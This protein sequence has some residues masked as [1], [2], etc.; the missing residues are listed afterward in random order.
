[1]SVRHSK[2]FLLLA[3]AFLAVLYPAIGWLSHQTNPLAPSAAGSIK[4]LPTFTTTPQLWPLRQAN[5]VDISA[6][7]ATSVILIDEQTGSIL[8]SRQAN[9][10]RP[11]ASLTKIMTAAI[12][13]EFAQ[14]DSLITIPKKATQGLPED[15]ALMG[16]TSGEQ[17]TVQELLYGLLLPSGNDAAQAL[18]MAIAGDQKRFVALMNAKVA[19]LGLTNTHFTNPSGLDEANHYTTAHDLAVITH[20]AQSFALFN[21]IVTTK[22]KALPYTAQHK[23]LDLVNANAFISSYP[24]ATGIKP[25]NTGEAG[26][27]LVASADRQGHQILGVLLD[28]PGRNTNMAAMFDDAFTQLGVL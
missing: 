22:E 2:L 3:I 26:N 5:T 13:L 23:A 9:I 21:Q 27:C 15:S 25:G 20:Y 4:P 11:M 10:R 16:I 18:A 24:G 19:Q 17:Y 1:M 7:Q 12:V 6:I 8:A 14:P 28:T